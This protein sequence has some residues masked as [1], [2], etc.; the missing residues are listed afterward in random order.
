VDKQVLFRLD[1]TLLNRLD[2]VL[3]SAGYKTRNAWFKEVVENYLAK[4]EGM[5]GG[6]PNRQPVKS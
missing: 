3:G 5:G 2:R 1:E 4:N 6:G